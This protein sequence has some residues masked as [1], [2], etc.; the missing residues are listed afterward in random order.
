M[1]DTGK[2]SVEIRASDCHRG[3]SK[4][5]CWALEFVMLVVTLSNI[6]QISLMSMNWQKS[7]SLF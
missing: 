7:E 2:E 6:N 3:D 1:E 4:G 5:D